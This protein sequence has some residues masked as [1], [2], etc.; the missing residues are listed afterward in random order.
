MFNPILSPHTSTATPL[1]S[2]S[3]PLSFV[4]GFLRWSQR[5]LVM[6]A[7]VFL[8]SV[9]VFFQAP[10]VRQ[11][12]WLSLALTAGILWLSFWLQSRSKTKLWGDLLLGFTGSWLA[13]S[14]YWGWLR[15]E[16]VLHLPVEAICLPVALWCA[17]RR[18]CQVGAWF[19]LGSLFGT[20]IT[21]LYFYLAD[22]I[23]HWRKIM[24][25]DPALALP[26]FQSAIR[27]VQTPWGISW[28]AVLLAVLLAAGLAPLKSKQ[29]HW[30]AFGGAVLSTILVDGLFWIAASAV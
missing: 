24:Q 14:L 25:V 21:D 20:A 7:S 18:R 2:G 30:W 27:Q 29:L 23:P 3:H 22:L 28:A 17:M 1:L 15:W 11:L 12:P 5:R 19:Y 6:A 4:L 10:L 8:V 9:P 13:G 26:V 16:P